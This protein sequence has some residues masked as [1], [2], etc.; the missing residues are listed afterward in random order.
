VNPTSRTGRY[1]GDETRV[2]WK[3]VDGRVERMA[4][5]GMNTLLLE[6]GEAMEFACLPK[7]HLR[8]QVKAAEVNEHIRK[9]KDM[10][11]ETVPIL[12]FS[13]IHSEWM[14][15]YCRMTATPP[16]REKCREII[17]ETYETLEK[18]RF[19][20]IG[21]ADETNRLN[22]GDLVVFRQKEVLWNEL[23]FF[24]DEI[25]KTGARPW[26]WGD[27]VGTHLDT[28]AGKLPKDFL[29]SYRW[30]VNVTTGDKIPESESKWIETFDR[31]DAAGYDQVPVCSTNGWYQR[32]RARSVE[33]VLNPPYLAKYVRSHVSPERLKGICCFGDYLPD[34]TGDRVQRQTC[35]V[36][37]KV[38]KNWDSNSG[39]M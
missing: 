28:F 30:M 31:I 9:W 11:I 26:M 1:L 36:F 37:G 16:Y 34:E 21:M 39:T 4:A 18:P 22:D 20:H 29:V 38:K 33:T 10:G 23:K 17:R 27:A 8:G 25:V 24:S 35:E 6:L 15:E 19:I 14:G 13:A 12:E 2:D 32:G 5:A 7:A 3:R